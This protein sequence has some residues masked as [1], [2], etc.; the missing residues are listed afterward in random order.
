MAILLLRE[1]KEFFLSRLEFIRLIWAVVSTQTRSCMKCVT[2]DGKNRTFTSSLS[3]MSMTAFSPRI[4]FKLSF[5][6]ISPKSDKPAS[7]FKNSLW[8]NKIIAKWNHLNLP[9]LRRNQQSGT[10]INANSSKPQTIGQVYSRV[11]DA[12]KPSDVISA[13]C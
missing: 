6:T 2:I 9:T 12:C 8:N 10:L 1:A 5:S 11:P 4:I 3:H 13:W 7:I